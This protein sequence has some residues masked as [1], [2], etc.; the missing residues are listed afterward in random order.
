MQF[1]VRSPQS[2]Y[3]AT[4]PPAQAKIKILHACRKDT[5]YEKLGPPPDE[6]VR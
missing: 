4:G 3:T 6:S 5:M 2:G 1:R